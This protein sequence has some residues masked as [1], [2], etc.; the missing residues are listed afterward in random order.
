MDESSTN[1]KR[2]LA[3]ISNSGRACYQECAK[4]YEYE[5]ILRRLPARTAMPLMF[6]SVFHA[7]TEAINMGKP[8]QPAVDAAALETGLDSIYDQAKVEAMLTCYEARYSDDAS[9]EFIEVEKRIDAPV[10]NP[11][12]NAP[13]RTWSFAGRCDALVYLIE[14]R[15]AELRKKK[16]VFETKTTSSDISP[17]SEF[18]QNLF[19][20]PQG[21]LYVAGLRRGSMLHADI[22]G[23]VYDAA[24]KPD[25]KP[26]LATPVEKRKYKKDGTLY[27]NVRLEDESVNQYKAR[28]IE[29]IMQ[30]PDKYFQRQIVK[31]GD[32]SDAE[33]NLW[34]VAKNISA[35]KRTGIFPKNSG[36]CFKWNRA[37][38]YFGVCTG[39]AGIGDNSL[40]RDGKPRY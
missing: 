25:M 11:E 1:G 8:W 21:Q 33:F 38:S 27:A 30:D 18:W 24:R 7:G 23:I 36:A 3:I 17:G 5:H 39:N 4:K 40:F 19:M 14:R 28:L 10:V 34:N 20:K 15:A 32:T 37:C 13:S 29:A 31:V 9:L 16:H 26:R 35:S 6:G 12:T 2:T 22:V